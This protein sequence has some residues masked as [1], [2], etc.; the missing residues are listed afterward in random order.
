LEK[1]PLIAIVMA[2]MIEAK[3]FVL[4]MS[5]K[6]IGQKP[7]SLFR[8]DNVF[9]VISGIGKANAAM[10]AAYCCK[11]FYPSCICN[12]GSAG[13]TVVSHS[14]GEI[15][16]INKIF[17]YDRPEFITGNPHIHEPH[18]LDGFPIAT[19]S[20]SDKAILDPEERK[21]V[22]KSADLMDMEGASVVQACRIFE[23]KCY[24]FKYVSDTPEHTDDKDIINN[25]RLYRTQFYE[26]FLHSVMP[27]ISR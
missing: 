23:T 21:E 5:M 1:D 15:F 19:L 24:M 6:K 26:F 14:L 16:H 9:L 18:V 22:S 17:E 12:L 7:F 27:V 10:A 13:A 2:T 11:E 8:N 3:P 4:G 20:T 25:I